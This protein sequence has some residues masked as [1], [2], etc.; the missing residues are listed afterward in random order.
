M[1]VSWG[2]YNGDGWVDLY[3]GNMFS[4]AG[5]RIAFQ[6]KFAPGQSEQALAEL[7]RTARGNTLFENAGDG[8]FHDVSEIKN[9]TMGRWAWSSKFA[10][11][12]NDTRLDLV[13]ANGFLSSEDSGDL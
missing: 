7:Q 8:T 5:N 3:V 1:S 11:L 9:V 10:D 6:R 4:G 12:N 2:D 13:V